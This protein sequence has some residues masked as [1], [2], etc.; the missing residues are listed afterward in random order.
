MVN[1]GRHVHVERIFNFYFIFLI[2]KKVRKNFKV[3]KFH[4]IIYL[5][6]MIFLFT[7]FLYQLNRPK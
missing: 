6:P 1:F 5:F 2:L 3:V 7:L 4:F